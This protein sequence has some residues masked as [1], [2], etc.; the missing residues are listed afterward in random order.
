MADTGVGSLPP[1]ITKLKE[2]SGARG[3]VLRVRVYSMQE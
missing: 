3:D 1:I 2:K